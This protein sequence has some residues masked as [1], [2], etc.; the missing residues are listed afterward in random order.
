MKWKLNQFHIQSIRIEFVNWMQRKERKRKEKREKL[1]IGHFFVFVRFSRA[2]LCFPL[3][4]AQFTFAQCIQIS[5]AKCAPVSFS[6]ARASTT[7]TA[8]NAD[9]EQ[10]KRSEL[11]EQS[12]CLRA[13]SKN[14]NSKFEFEA[15]TSSS[16]DRQTNKQTHKEKQARNLTHAQTNKRA[17]QNL[18]HVNA[19]R[20]YVLAAIA[21]S[22]PFCLKL[23][24]FF[25]LTTK[26][27][28]TTM[29]N[30]A[31]K[32]SSLRHIIVCF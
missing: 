18:T 17:Q 1:S 16:A 6:P 12:F 20:I 22:L 26:T 32:M 11:L 14:S 13:R 23:L 3:F 10:L 7:L 27:T 5:T 29:H 8:A 9:G 15:L 31:P 19:V 28:T 4:A 2:N 30:E 21:S 24:S 25:L